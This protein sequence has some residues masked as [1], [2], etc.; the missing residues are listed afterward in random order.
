MSIEAIK[1]AVKALEYAAGLISPITKGCQCQIC[2]AHTA[3]RQAIAEAEKQE[4]VAWI[5]DGE[6]KVR[7]DMAGKLY[8]SETNVYAAPVHAIDISQER[9]DETAKCGHEPVAQ[10]TYPKCQATNGCVGVCSKEPVAWREVAGKT[11]HY[12]D[13]NEEGRGEPLY[14][15]REWVGLDGDIPGLGLVT[16]EFYN[17]M[18]CAEDILRKR[19]T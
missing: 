6:I 8:Y 4:P 11:T 1:Q 18:L 13:Y 7:L 16:E 9:V 3:L 17:G 19:N 12:Y 10:C 15:H 14:L 2:L 5:V